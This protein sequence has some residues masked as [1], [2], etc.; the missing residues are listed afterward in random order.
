[1]WFFITAKQLDKMEKIQERALRFVTG[2][3]NSSYETLL[4]TTEMTNMRVRQ[5]QNQCIKIFKTLNNMNLPYMQE[6]FER[7]SSSYSTRRPHDL[8]LPRV[9]QTSFGSRSIKFEGARL[10]NHLPQNIK[11][12]DTFKQLIKNWMGPSCGYSYCLFVERTEQKTFVTDT[13]SL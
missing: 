4:N 1:M 3:Y 11:S 6:L 7:S 10:W 8:M 2:D 9:N 5:M 12:A 13:L